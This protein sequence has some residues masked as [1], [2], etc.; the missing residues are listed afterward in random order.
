[1][2]FKTV[3]KI[4]ER[5]TS[6]IV[7]SNNNPVLLANSIQYY[8]EKGYRVTN[9]ESFP[10]ATSMRSYNEYRKNYTLETYRDLKGSVIVIMEK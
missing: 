7:L 3:E 6:Q 2:S 9:M 10:V 4:T 1:M 8:F 5:S